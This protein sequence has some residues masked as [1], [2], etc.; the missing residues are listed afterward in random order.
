MLSKYA[1]LW[2]INHFPSD[3][4]SRF[5]LFAP[6]DIWNLTWV[7]AFWGWSCLYVTPHTFPDVT[8]L[9][10]Q[11]VLAVHTLKTKSDCWYWFLL[12]TKGD[13][14]FRL[15]LENISKMTKPNLWEMV[16]RAWWF[17]GKVPPPP[18]IYWTHPGFVT[19]P[20][21][22]AAHPNARP[23]LQLRNFSLYPTRLLIFIKKKKK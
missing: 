6:A 23:L 9:W 16:E 8:D 7:C 13:H 4:L 14:R 1:G 10:T 3:S 11:I 22:W 17:W 2:S 19:P 12:N 15:R 20:L 21:P 18:V 5:L